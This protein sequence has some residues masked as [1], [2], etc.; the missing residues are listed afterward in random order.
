MGNIHGQPISASI[1]KVNLFYVLH[2]QI[3]AQLRFI[4]PSPIL[5]SEA[6]QIWVTCYINCRFLV[7]I[8]GDR[9]YVQIELDF[10]GATRN[11]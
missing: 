10:L 7:D 5:F 4:I 2:H 11:I 8:Q 6:Q 9:E 3:A 1:T